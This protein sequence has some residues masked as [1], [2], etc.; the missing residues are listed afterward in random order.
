VWGSDDPQ[1][2]LDNGLDLYDLFGTCNAKTTRMYVLNRAGHFH[3]REHPNEFNRVV[4][5]F[6]RAHGPRP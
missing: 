5:D 3:F 1:A 4:T 2:V 6:L